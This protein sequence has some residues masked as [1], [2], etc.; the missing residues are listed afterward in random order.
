MKGTDKP[1]ANVKA[2][3]SILRQRNTSSYHVTYILGESGGEET[4]NFPR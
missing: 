4:S 1:S 3:L 2:L